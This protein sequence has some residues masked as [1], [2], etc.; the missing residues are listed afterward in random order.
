[1]TDNSISEKKIEDPEKKTH[2]APIGKW[3]ILSSYG[4][5]IAQ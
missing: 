3:K 2:F 4:R 1:M 5:H